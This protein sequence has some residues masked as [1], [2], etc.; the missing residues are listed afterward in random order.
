MLDAVITPNGVSVFARTGNFCEG[1]RALK[2]SDFRTIFSE[3]TGATRQRCPRFKLHHLHARVLSLG[4]RDHPTATRSPWQNGYAERL[5][6]SIRRECLDQIVVIG[7]VGF[8]GA[9]R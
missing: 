4:I 5:I 8:S 9:W 3:G 6:G 1:K 2:Q 7:E